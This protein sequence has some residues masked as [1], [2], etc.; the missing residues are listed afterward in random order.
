MSATQTSRSTPT[1][2]LGNLFRGDQTLLLGALASLVLAFTIIN[3]AAFMSEVNLRSI[4]I[5]VSIFLI[6]GVGQTFVIMTRGIDLSIGSVLVVSGMV[7]VITTNGL[8]GRDAGLG[9]VLIG[10]IVAIAVGLAFGL[11]NGLAITRLGVP[12]LIVTLGTMGIALGAAQ[13]MSNGQ[14]LSTV[15]T[16]LSD[17]IGFGRLGPIPLIVIIALVIV[18]IGAIVLN[19]HR[20]G[21]YVSAIGSN[22][23]A[24][25][26]AGISVNRRLIAVYAAQGALAGVA[27]VISLA[28]FTTTTISGHGNDSLA[29]IAGVVLGGTSLFGGLGT[30]LGMVLGMLIPAVLRSGLV[31]SGVQPFWQAIVTGFVLII[32]VYIDQVRRRRRA[33]R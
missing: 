20:A 3:P 29:V 17:S 19:L 11:F 1:A 33:N 5:D 18:G 30:M 4:A 10:V 27:A 21:R 9:A 13:V 28:R 8:G 23:E 14:D 26:R 15:P 7:S 25:R 2:R 32:A 24:A 12:P 31:I 22:P 6:M 16:L